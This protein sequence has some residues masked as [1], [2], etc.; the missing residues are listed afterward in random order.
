MTTTGPEVYISIMS[1]FQST[2]HSE[3][4]SSDHADCRTKPIV[5]LSSIIGLCAASQQVQSVSWMMWRA[6]DRQGAR[7][8]MQNAMPVLWMRCENASIEELADTP[9]MDMRAAEKLYRYFHGS[10]ADPTVQK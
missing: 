5:L 6:S 9:S 10:E 4:L 7:H 8:L 3:G 2:G 1:L